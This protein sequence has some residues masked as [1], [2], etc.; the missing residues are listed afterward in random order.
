MVNWSKKVHGA[1][2]CELFEQG[3]AD[4]KGNTADEID[5]FWKL[6]PCFEQITIDRFRDNFRKT[7]AA[8]IRGKGLQGIR[9]AGEKK[10]VLYFL[11]A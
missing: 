8:Y 2:L 3:L 4:P 7:A 9:R 6:D 5:R 10:T 1:K 11:F